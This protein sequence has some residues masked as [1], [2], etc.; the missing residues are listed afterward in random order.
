MSTELDPEPLG[1][2]GRITAMPFIHIRSLPIG[3]AFDAG[4]AV[5]A[6]SSEF[7]DAVE[8][9]ERH[10]TVTWQ[11][12]E[13]D[14]YASAGQTAATQPPGSHPVLVGLRGGAACALGLAPR[15]GRP[16][17][18]LTASASERAA[19]TAGRAR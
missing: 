8:V 11:T 17:G 18:S 12:L 5:R 7:A 6:V 13:P 15:F 19:P 1:L 14:H 16:R 3:A 2:G 4:R 10:V 9:D